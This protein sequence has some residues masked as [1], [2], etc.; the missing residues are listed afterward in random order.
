MTMTARQRADLRGE[1]HHLRPSVHV[2]HQGLTD[3]LVQSLEDALR[4]RELVKVTLAK[5]LRR[6]LP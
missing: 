3:A 4:I 5:S 1:A 2:G 6:Q